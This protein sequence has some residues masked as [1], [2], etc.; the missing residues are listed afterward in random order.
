M[1]GF[2]VEMIMIVKVLKKRH[3]EEI[4][5]LE[6]F[7]EYFPPTI[8]MLNFVTVQNIWPITLYLANVNQQNNA[9]IVVKYV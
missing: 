4:L 6:W 5:C 1:T 2:D 8:Q 9:A 3:N 7:V